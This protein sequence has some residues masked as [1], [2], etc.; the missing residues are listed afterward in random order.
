VEALVAGK[1]GWPP[2]ATTGDGV[3]EGIP[4]AKLRV[5]HPNQSSRYRCTPPKILDASMSE[6][7]AP[8][9]TKEDLMCLHPPNHQHRNPGTCPWLPLRIAH[10]R[11]TNQRSDLAIS[12]RRTQLRRQSL[13]DFETVTKWADLPRAVKVRGQPLT[14]TDNPPMRCQWQQRREYLRT[15]L[16]RR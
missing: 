9:S 6:V 14:A 12:L 11:P 2:L 10:H 3:G 1:E 4:V 16:R 7:E 13:N 5:A 15:K 8:V